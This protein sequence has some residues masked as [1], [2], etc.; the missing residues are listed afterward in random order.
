MWYG[1]IL[2]LVLT[3]TIFLLTPV[4]GQDPGTCFIVYFFYLRGVYDE[5]V[6]IQ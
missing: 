6:C 1:N 2:G 5:M 4:R 3:Q